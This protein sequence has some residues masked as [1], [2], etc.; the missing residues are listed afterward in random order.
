MPDFEVGEETILG[1]PRPAIV[2][3]VLALSLLVGCRQHEPQPH[4]SQAE[5]FNGRWNIDVKSQERHSPFWMEVEGAGTGS[6][7]GRFIGATGGR[8]GAFIDPQIHGGELSFSVFR[9]YEN[10]SEVRP[11]TVARLAGDRLVGTTWIRDEKVEWEGRR[12]P[13]IGD[14]DDGGWCEGETSVLFNGAD[15]S[16]WHTLAPDREVGWTV[17]GSV[18]KNGAGRGALLV[19]N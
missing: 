11:K 12:P 15:L 5:G 18:L 3:L 6:L 17:D 9:R 14:R 16:T 1:R 10:N 4:D 19:S 13:Q 7:K 2:F 8:A